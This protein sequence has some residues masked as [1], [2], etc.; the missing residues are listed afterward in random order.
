MKKVYKCQAKLK[1]G[2]KIKIR[3]A[4]YIKKHFK[5]Y[6]KPDSPWYMAGCSFVQDMFK[7]AGH[8]CT[9]DSIDW[10]KIVEIQEDR[11]GYH[12]S[13]DLYRKATKKE[14]ENETH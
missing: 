9:I 7:F 14:I 12:F 5:R 10:L 3:D 13:P 11:I 8:V 2:D 1:R 4:E 6:G